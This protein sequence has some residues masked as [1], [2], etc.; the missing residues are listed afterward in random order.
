MEFI[1]EFVYVFF[2]FQDSVNSLT[3]EVSEPLEEDNA[4]VAAAVNE[5]SVET[6]EQVDMVNQRRVEV[7]SILR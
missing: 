1:A 6:E 7:L 5:E 4:Q 2:F 3:V